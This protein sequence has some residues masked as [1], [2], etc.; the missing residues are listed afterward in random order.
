MIF[1]NIITE[2]HVF[3]T[4]RV[5]NRD[6]VLNEAHAAAEGERTLKID[7]K[8]IKLKQRYVYNIEQVHALN[9]H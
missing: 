1:H 5:L 8:M 4:N 7:F 3:G 2:C 6:S 9:M